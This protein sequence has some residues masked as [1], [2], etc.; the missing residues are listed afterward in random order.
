MN[1]QWDHD[2][3]LRIAAQESPDGCERTERTCKRCGIVKIT[4]HPADDR[5][6]P[7]R[8]WRTAKGKIWDGQSTPPCVVQEVSA[9]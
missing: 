7:W 9:L 1:H 5:G 6:F 2:H 8:Q 4:V 3:E